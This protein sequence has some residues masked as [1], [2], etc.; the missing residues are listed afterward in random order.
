MSLYTSKIDWSD[1][2]NGSVGSGREARGSSNRRTR[3]CTSMSRRHEHAQRRTH[4]VVVPLCVSLFVPF[5]F[6]WGQGAEQQP[7]FLSI[8]L[9]TEH[10]TILSPPYART[11]PWGMRRQ[12][13]TLF[14][15]ATLRSIVP[16]DS[17]CEHNDRSWARSTTASISGSMMGDK[18]FTLSSQ[19]NS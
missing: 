14:S 16:A 2:D 13:C 5:C 6:V 17:P 11:Q 9:R 7:T 3:S 10:I 4:V 15:L 1:G 8:H 18:A 19:K 12:A